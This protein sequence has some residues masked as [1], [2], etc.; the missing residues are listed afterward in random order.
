MSHRSKI[1]TLIKYLWESTEHR[2][3]FRSITENKDSFI[4][5]ANGIMNETN[6]LI[7]TVMQKLPE[8]RVAQE[9][10]KNPQEWSQLSEEQQGQ[11]SS[12]LDDNER[13]V[14]H[15][16]PL[17]NRTLQMFSYLNS[18]PDIR[19]LF[20][21]P[22][23][24][25]RLVGMLQHVLVKLVGSR[26]LELKVDDPEQYEFRP[27]EMLRDLC[28]I[29]AVFAASETFQVECAKSGC[30]PN[31]LRDAAKPLRKFNLLVGESMTAFESLPD[32]IDIAL[33]HV[34][35]DDELYEGAPEEFMDELLS[36]VMMDPVKLPSGHIV[37]RSTIMQHMLNSPTNPFSREPLEVEDIVPATELKAK[38]DAWVAEKRASRQQA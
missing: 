10:M 25:S 8:I 2:P 6:T 11:V 30:S 4:K 9:Q 37:D 29:F 31:L 27:K 38:M 15:A 35:A 26:G 36:T 17:A 21:L 32:A 34:S 22:E 5:F 14:K 28:S 20:L 19:K 33:K 24:C 7:A 18:D 16:L 12:R 3:A 1:A 23:L 13:E